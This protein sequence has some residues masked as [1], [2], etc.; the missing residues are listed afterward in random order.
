MVDERHKSDSSEQRSAESR[1]LQRYGESRGVTLTAEEITLPSGARIQVDGVGNDGE[2]LI[3]CE[4]FAHQGTPKPG[5]KKKVVADAFKLV[6]A[7]KD[8][9]RDCEKILLFADETAEAAFRGKA[10]FAMAFK[11]FGVETKTVDLPLAERNELRAAQTR[12]IR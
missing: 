2:K 8:L 6:Y 5:Q 4:V 3:L 7:E 9:D 10:W 11:A 12:Q 1:I